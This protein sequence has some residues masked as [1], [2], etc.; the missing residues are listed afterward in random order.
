MFLYKIGLLQTGGCQ[1]GGSVLI[2][3]IGDLS[4]HTLSRTQRLSVPT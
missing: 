1:L 2:G 4:S 3:K